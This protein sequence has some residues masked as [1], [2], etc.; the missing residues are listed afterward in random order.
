VRSDS[1]SALPEKKDPSV[2]KRS[3]MPKA[4]PTMAILLRTLLPT[5]SRVTVRPMF[6]HTAAFVNGQM[7]AGT[8]GSHVF[9]RLNES[10]RAELLAVPGATVFAP[11]KDRP[12]SGQDLPFM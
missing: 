1:D 4:D 3:T 9:A 12:T 11:M 5:D 8:F 7:F 10:M 6:G 2:A